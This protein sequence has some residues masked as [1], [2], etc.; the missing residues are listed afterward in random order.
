MAL[1]QQVFLFFYLFFFLY[2]WSIFTTSLLQVGRKKSSFLRFRVNLR[3]LFNC[4]GKRCVK[5][6]VKGGQKTGIPCFFVL[7]CNALRVKPRFWV[8][9]LE[10]IGKQKWCY[11]GQKA[12]F[13]IMTDQ[14]VDPEHR[15]DLITRF[16]FIIFFNEKQRGKQFLEWEKIE[17]FTRAKFQP[18]EILLRKIQ[19]QR[20]LSF[21]IFQK[22]AKIQSWMQ[23]HLFN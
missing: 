9:G 1:G 17:E 6:S 15:T 22:F 10:R 11:S 16:F 14:T 19:W 2:S 7:I 3:P 18:P 4:L 12:F 8:P 5:K 13:T 20:L 23:V 21:G